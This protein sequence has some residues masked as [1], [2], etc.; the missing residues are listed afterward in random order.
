MSGP[1]PPGG[2]LVRADRELLV[3]AGRDRARFLNGYLTCDLARV[4]AGQLASGFVTSREGRVLADVEV[5]DDGSRLRMAVPAGRGAALLEHLARYVLAADVALGEL[6]GGVVVGV[7]GEAAR[8]TLPAG[9]LGRPLGTL[10]GAELWVDRGDLAGV[11]ADLQEAGVAALDAAEFDR[12]RVDALFGLFGRDFDA[13]HFPQ[14]TGRG[15]AA[16]S[17]TKGCYLG[18]EIVARIHFRGGVPRSLRALA[19]AGVPEPGTALRVE[20]REAGR[21][22]TVAAAGGGGSVGLAVLHRRAGAAG[23]RVELAAGGEGTLFDPPFAAP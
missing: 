18:Q 1:P 12:L 5:A 2:F 19:F 10:P 21:L 13:Q 6:D 14:E 22:G 20:G 4:E 15:A 3:V 9:A 16:V 17:T 7:Y 23:S 11:R 8:G